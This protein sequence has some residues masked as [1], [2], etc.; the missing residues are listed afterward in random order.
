M[1]LLFLLLLLGFV[2]SSGKMCPPNACHPRAK[3]LDQR[4]SFQESYK[5]VVLAALRRFKESKYVYYRDYSLQLVLCEAVPS[6][7][8]EFSKRD[9][10]PQP[11]DAK[12]NSWRR[13][14]RSNGSVRYEV[15]GE[16]RW[17]GDP[18][19]VWTFS[20]DKGARVF[21]FIWDAAAKGVRF[22]SEIGSFQNV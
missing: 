16:G 20:T 7:Q 15:R 2:H 4:E 13:V 14:G 11:E 17:H 12:L 9:V 22:Y 10:V 5:K 1:M 18:S 3:Q 19:I 21:S 6:A 8:P